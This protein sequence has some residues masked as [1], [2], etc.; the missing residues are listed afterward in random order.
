[1]KLKGRTA[2]VTGGARG[3]ITKMGRQALLAQ[4]DVADYPD[5]FRMEENVL[6]EFGHLDILVNNAGINSDKTF[7]KMDHAAWRNVL[8]I[9]LDRVFNCT[10]VFVDQ[11]LKQNYG[12]LREVREPAPLT[13]QLLPPLLRQLHSVP[14]S[15]IWN[16]EP[17]FM[18]NPISPL[19][20]SFPDMN[21]I[22]PF[23]F[24]DSMSSQSWAPICRVR[25]GALAAPSV[26][27]HVLSL[28]TAFQVPP[29]SPLTSYWITAVVPAAR[30]ALKREDICSKVSFTV[31]MISPFR[32]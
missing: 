20:L 23:C 3:S 17:S 24:P 2:L 12:C 22:C 9:N 14:L 10:K 19:I 29:P 7:V 28:M 4:A 5:T 27:V 21:S 6:A 25:F 13:V 31:G 26:T 16:M 18:A 1:M 32:T 30:S 11:M 8:S 15:Y